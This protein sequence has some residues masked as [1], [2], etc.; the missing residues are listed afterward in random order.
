MRFLLIVASCLLSLL[1]GAARAA[2]VS[3]G[4]IQVGFAGHYKAGEWTPLNVRLEGVVPLEG[5]SQSSGWIVETETLDADGSTVVRASEP[6]S[7]D[8]IEGQSWLRTVFQAGRL[9]SSLTVRVR[10]ASGAAHAERRF[11][12]GTEHLPPALTDD[13]PLWVS[14]L[15]LGDTRENAEPG[16]S[17]QLVLVTASMPLPSDPLAYRAVDLLVV[18][19]DLDVSPEAFA[20]I[21]RYVAVGGRLMISL[22][23]R[24]DQFESA[25][26]AEWVPIETAGTIQL[27][28]FSDLEDFAKLQPGLQ[29]LPARA[30]VRIAAM[31]TAAKSVLPWRGTNHLLV[32]RDAF[33]FGDVTL[34]AFDLFHPTFAHWNGLPAFI[35][36]SMRDAPE[37]PGPPRT[38]SNV[39]DLATQLI[40][41]EDDFPGLRR[42]SVGQALLLLL[43]FA[44]IVGPLDYLLVHRWLKRPA[45]TW[46]T[47]PLL[48]V[49]AAWWLNY[50]AYAANGT[51]S[52]Y[53]ELTLWDYDVASQTTRGKSI[54]SLYATEPVRADLVAHPEGIAKALGVESEEN[55]PSENP[56]TGQMGWIAVPEENFGGLYRDASGGMF[57]PSY[58]IGGT[59]GDQEGKGIPMLAWSS[60]QLSSIWSTEG[61][62]SPVSADLRAYGAEFLEGSISHDL[63]RPLKNWMILFGNQVYTPTDDQW[64]P[65]TPL[66]VNSSAI[67]RRDARSLLT[68]Q[69]QITVEKKSGE[70]GAEY[71]VKETAYDRTV[72]DPA[73]IVRML[74]F[75]DTAGGSDYTQLTNTLW[76][77]DD[78]SPLLGLGRAILW[79]EIEL[80]DSAWD[81]RAEGDVDFTPARRRT[82]VRIVLPV[83]KNTPRPLRPLKREE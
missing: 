80:P 61:Q 8:S 77:R 1:A 20:A 31:E 74:S 44:V 60:R 45:L 30:R 68:G 21:K 81:A 42:I 52:L 82:F 2:D 83:E 6:L 66:Q 22:G 24:T 50:S 33:G 39:S 3:I 17:E 11:R 23:E 43:L 59:G 48:V 72:A 28:E 47:L 49:G 75:H 15:P 51:Q 32:A 69:I 10:D 16:W 41:A 63:A 35:E 5:A 62:A 13:V 37:R 71:L 79:G 73:L 25:A 36:R 4:E 9:G 67:K 70:A 55:Q 29:R 57:L 53:N 19:G 58:Q 7:L 64:Q 54:I 12:A 40:L 26:L 76:S 27:R 18:P 14:T 56:L 78:L 38:D 65:R 34:V 46:I